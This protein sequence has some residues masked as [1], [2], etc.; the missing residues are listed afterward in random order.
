MAIAL[1]AIN[2]TQIEA[3]AAF[4]DLPLAILSTPSTDTEAEDSRR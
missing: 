2:N 4:F 1:N 3:T